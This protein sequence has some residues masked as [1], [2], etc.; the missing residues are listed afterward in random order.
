MHGAFRRYMRKQGAALCS[1]ENEARVAKRG[2]W[3][4]ANDDRITPWEYR[5]R[6]NRDSFIDYSH[7]TTAECVAASGK[8]RD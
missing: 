5:S 4:L 2:L 6:K 3:A 1:D 7:E 8:R